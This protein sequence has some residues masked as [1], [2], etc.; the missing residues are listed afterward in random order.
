MPPNIESWYQEIGRAGRDGLPSE[1]FL[2][3]SWA[4]VIARERFLAEIED[5]QLRREKKQAMVRMFELAD[6]SACR[7]KRIL[8]YF[9]ETIEPCR[10]SC[11]MCSGVHTSDLLTQVALET[12]R[13]GR[14]RRTSA[15]KDNVAASERSP[16]DPAFQR[17]RALRK[18]LADQQ[19]VPAYIVFGDQVLWNM[20]DRM[21]STKAELLEVSGVGP[22]KL[23]RY[24]DAFLAALNA[25]PQ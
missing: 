21:P 1:C 14:G 16:S 5:E 10:E 3:Y 19:R 6:S 18:M 13:S 23:D 11:D 22:A 8:A 20:I 12:K 9:D 2:F 24:G 4:D 25:S 17:L 7:H 15:V